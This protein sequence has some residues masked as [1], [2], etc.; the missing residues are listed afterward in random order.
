MS[1]AR[2]VIHGL[3]WSS[4]T[5]YLSVPINIAATV[6]LARLLEPT[7]FGVFALAAASC[8]VVFLPASMSLGQATIQLRGKAENLED[9]VV[10]LSA[11]LAGALG[12]VC[13]CLVPLFRSL[14]DA[15]GL[16]AFLV[17]AFA[18]SL[19]IVVAAQSASLESRFEYRFLAVARLSAATG[20]AIVSIVLAFSARGVEA[21]VARDALP[22]VITA[23][24]FLSLRRSA[25]I[26]GGSAW[27]TSTAKRVLK[28]GLGWFSVRSSEMLLHRVDQLLLA[29]FVS[30]YTL[31]LY[32]QARYL[33][34][35]PNAF[36]AGPTIQIALRTYGELHDRPAAQRE[37]HDLA[38]FF[39]L[40]LLVPSAVAMFA[41]P[42]AC[43]WLVFGNRWLAAAPILAAFAPWMVLV[44]LFES[45]KVVL[46]ARHQYVRTSLIYLVM[47]ATL[48]LGVLALVKPFGPIAG[49]VANTASFGLAMLLVWTFALPADWRPRFG[50]AVAPIL[51][52]AVVCMGAMYLRGRLDLGAAGPAGVFFALLTFVATLLVIVGLEPRSFLER[53][54]LVITRGFSR[55]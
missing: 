4:L 47:V 40:R 17:I 2:R 41:F 55:T 35:V 27:S 19:N 24:I 46:M 1:F 45:T 51:A 9:T 30:R 49:A 20:G 8:E 21:L 34:T 39:I 32:S 18:R 43:L 52:P 53:C 10:T 7:T 28:I 31:G 48:A 5:Y 23:A 6:L 15:E 16:F 22:V 54:R 37:I 50:S 44:P 14:F 42:E 29:P 38:R 36:V 25:R 33:A 12:L 11:L 13:V 3:L 26:P